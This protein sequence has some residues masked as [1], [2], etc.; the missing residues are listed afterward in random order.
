MLSLLP[1][2]ISKTLYRKC[3]HIHT[4]IVVQKIKPPKTNT[5]LPTKQRE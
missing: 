5:E 2:E 4:L 1:S 3:T